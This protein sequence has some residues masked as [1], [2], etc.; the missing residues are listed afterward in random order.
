MIQ[1]PLKSKTAIITGASTGI[2]RAIASRFARAGS[3]LVLTARDTKALE[4]LKKSLVKTPSKIWCYGCDL[5]DAE[6]LEQLILTIK[7]NHKKIDVL[8]NNAGIGRFAPIDEVTTEDWDRM[9]SLNLRAPLIMCRAFVPVMKRLGAGKIIN[10]SS[11][12]GKV[13]VAQ[14]SAYSATK[15]GLEGLNKSLYDELRDHNISVTSINPGSVD[16]PFFDG[17]SSTWLRREQ[18]LRPND[19]ADTALFIATRPQSVL[20]DSIELRPRARPVP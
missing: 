5:T 6:D 8:V 20:I 16:T 17:L 12:A 4:R 15:F 7:K 19:V 11:I 10:I 13:G 9:L 1:Q 14:A 18:M 3:N 2:G